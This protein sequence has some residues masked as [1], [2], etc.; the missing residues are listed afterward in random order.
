MIKFILN[1]KLIQSDDPPGTLLLDCI[2]YRE[3][4]TGTKI[5]C[6]EGDCGACTVLIGEWKGNKVVYRS[7][8]SCLTA[9]GNVHHQ[10]VVTIEGLNGDKLN[11]LQQ[12]I[13]DEGGTQCGFCTPGFIVSMAGF[14]LSDKAPTHAAAIAAVDGNICRCTGYKSIERAL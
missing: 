10:H 5:G 9:I 14:C 3:H 11:F 7:A 6:R 1:N 4:L 13:C 2:R 12:A 8:T